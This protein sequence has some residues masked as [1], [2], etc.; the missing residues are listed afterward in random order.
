MIYGGTR[1]YVF[2]LDP[3][4]GN[5]VWRTKLSTGFLFNAASAEDVMVL[6]VGEVIIAGCNGH[7]WGLAATTGEQLW[8][9]PLRGLGKGAVT[10]AAAG[11]AVHYVHKHTESSS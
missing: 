10:V 5:E 7:I 9:N 2:A 3:H 4:S 11:V 6:A 8:H 1:G